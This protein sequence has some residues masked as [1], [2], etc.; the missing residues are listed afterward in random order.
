MKD[1]PLGQERWRLVAGFL[2]HRFNDPEGWLASTGWNCTRLVG[3]LVT[4]IIP[5]IPHCARFF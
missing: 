4:I 3:L 5:V 1:L 2:A